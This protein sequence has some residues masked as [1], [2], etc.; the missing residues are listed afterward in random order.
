M[1]ENL[2]VDIAKAILNSLCNKDENTAFINHY[3]VDRSHSN[4]YV[5]AAEAIADLLEDWER[6]PG[7]IAQDLRVDDGF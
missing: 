7:S 6:Q 4:K 1:R 5:V 3:I 2:Y